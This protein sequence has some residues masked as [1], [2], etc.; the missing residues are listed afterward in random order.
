MSIADIRLAL[1]ALLLADSD[2]SAAVGGNRIYPAILPQGIVD[3][4]IVYNR[5]SGLGDQHSEGPSGLS[6]PRMQID[7]WART[8]ADAASLANLVKDALDGYRGPVQWDDDSPGNTITIQGV[9]YDSE[10]DIYDADAKLF[11]VSRDYFIW[12]EEK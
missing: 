3:P 4:S 1:R 7:C 8:A 6:R 5:I 11:G 10:R 9:F 12:Y 2:V